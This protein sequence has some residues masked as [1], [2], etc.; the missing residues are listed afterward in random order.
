MFV[1]FQFCLV[2]LHNFI[3]VTGLTFICLVIFLILVLW[4]FLDYSV[5]S[6]SKPPICY[7]FSFLIV[8]HLLLHMFYDKPPSVVIV[9]LWY[10]TL[11]IWFEEFFFTTE[12]FLIA[13]VT[14]ASPVQAKLYISFSVSRSILG[15]AAPCSWGWPWWSRQLEAVCWPPSLE[16]GNASFLGGVWGQGIPEAGTAEDGAGAPPVP[17][18]TPWALAIMEEQGEL[19]GRQNDVGKGMEIGKQHISSQSQYENHC[20]LGI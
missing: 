17:W 2:F 10:S 16:P 15:E 14:E 8:D 4:I 3:L 12:S 19:P 5:L 20:S 6:S 13:C 9:F 1:L 7:L 11:I 18:R